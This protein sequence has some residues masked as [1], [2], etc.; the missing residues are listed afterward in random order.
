MKQKFNV[1]AINIVKVFFGIFIILYFVLST[2]FSVHVNNLIDKFSVEYNF[3]L[4][5][6]VLITL[7]ILIFV[8]YS[9]IKNNF[10]NISDKKLLFSFLAFSFAIG[11]IW[12]FSNNIVLSE[13]DDAQSC[14]NTA[15][16]FINGEYD[17]LKHASYIAV[18]PNNIG[19]VLYDVLNIFLF[20]EVGALYSIRLINLV[21]VII[22]YYYLYKICDLTFN[23]NR[24]INC[25]MLFLMFGSMQF[26]FYSYFVYGNCLS[27]SLGIVSVYYLMNY[28]KENKHSHLIISIIMIL[29]SIFIK[30]NS[31]IIFIAE[32]IYC[33][34][35]IVNTKN[36]KILIC[37][38]TLIIGSICVTTGVEHIFENIIDYSYKDEKLPTITW[39]AYGVNYDANNPGHYTSQ[40]ELFH[41]NNGF[42]SEY[43][44]LEAERF[45]NESISYFKENPLAAIKFYLSKFLVSWANP[46]YEAF[47]QFRYSK[48]SDFTR[49]VV[50]GTINHLIDIF[51][52]SMQIIV[53]IGLLVFVIKGFK[54]TNI[55]QLLCATIVVGGVLFHI[56]WE[57]KAIYLYQYYMYLLPYGAHGLVMLA[58]KYKEDNS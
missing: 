39:L 38:F 16:N 26:V 15:I 42:K 25:S 9:L 2:L 48:N 55:Y 31:L 28:F 3:G 52:D 13:G 30:N 17:K 34:I 47:G 46:Q 14:F 24:L 7:T 57:V 32:L 49:Q 20:G 4:N 51:W 36:Y 27:Y 40:I 10:F 11:L 21:F 54:S 35:N 50:G 58:N 19:L 45:F 12:I 56:A 44:K 1:L 6:Y 43:T 53:A 23:H 37:I 8:L 41:E 5:V 22:G 29:V 18:Y 33:V